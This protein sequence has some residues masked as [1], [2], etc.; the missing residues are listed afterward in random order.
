MMI[1]EWGNKTPEKEMSSTTNTETGTNT[2]K[3]T[4]DPNLQ[5]AGPWAM[6]GHRFLM[7]ITSVD[8]SLRSMGVTEYL[9]MEVSPTGHWMK[10][11]NHNGSMFWRPT[12]D[13][14]TVE[15]LD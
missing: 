11:K 4:M 3:P 9:V 14:Q 10:L 12:P 8:G 15:A 13:V 5:P 2:R 6:R 7:K 1:E